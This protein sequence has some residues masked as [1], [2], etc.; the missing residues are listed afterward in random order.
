MATPLRHGRRVLSKPRQVATAGLDVTAVTLAELEGD[1][2][3][4]AHLQNTTQC[5]LI[6]I[7][8]ATFGVVLKQPMLQCHLHTNP[9]FANFSN[10]VCR[11]AG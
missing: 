10:V 5:V 7:V 8:R 11:C 2:L 3:R 6:Q 9:A 4:N 1:V